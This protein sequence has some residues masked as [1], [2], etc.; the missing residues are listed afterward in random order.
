[1]KKHLFCLLL[2]LVPMLATAMRPVAV[3]KMEAEFRQVR[4]SELNMRDTVSTGI[5]RFDA[6]ANLLHWSYTD[7]TI[8]QMPTEMMA[9]LRRVLQG[10]FYGKNPDFEMHKEGATLIITPKKKAL[11]KLYNE[12]HVRF[13]PFTGYLQE[14]TFYETTGPEPMTDL[15]GDIIT[16]DFFN[17][18][19][20]K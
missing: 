4:S 14:L 16:V 12:I 5:F 6:D 11:K 9:V 20:T 13:N 18:D 8:W 17:L 19:V 15:R 1:M 7:G 2:A 10:T 3:R